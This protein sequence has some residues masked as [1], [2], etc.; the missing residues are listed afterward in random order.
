MWRRIG[1]YNKLQ[2]DIIKYI[3]TRIEK[4]KKNY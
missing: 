1:D 3:N 4:R 2:T